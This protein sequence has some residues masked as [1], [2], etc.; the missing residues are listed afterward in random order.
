M[1]KRIN[2]N[3]VS[4]GATVS[5]SKR[6]KTSSVQWLPVSTPK[7]EFNNY[8]NQ[9]KSVFNSRQVE[10]SDTAG[11]TMMKLVRLMFH[12]YQCY[13]IGRNQEC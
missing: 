13:D 1:V 5:P 12:L 7:D 11:S 2:T 4:D 9:V 6:R 3:G 8:T 10:F